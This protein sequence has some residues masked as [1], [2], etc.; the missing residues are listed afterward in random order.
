[1]DQVPA[2]PSNKASILPSASSEA[3]SDTPTAYIQTTLEAHETHAFLDTES[4][5][6]LISEDLGMSISTLRIKVLSNNCVIV[7]SVT[8]DYLDTLA[9]P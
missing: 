8:G 1:M 4:V 2:H 3:K 5:T 9:F 6:S 7:K